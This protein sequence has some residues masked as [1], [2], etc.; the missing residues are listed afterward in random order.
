MKKYNSLVKRTNKLANSVASQFS[1]SVNI[2]ENFVVYVKNNN[3]TAGLTLETKIWTVE[4]TAI[5]KTKTKIYDFSWNIEIKSFHSTIIFHRYRKFPKHN[6][7]WVNKWRRIDFL[8]EYRCIST[9]WLICLLLLYRSLWNEI[10]VL[11]LAS[12]TLCKLIFKKL[13]MG[14]W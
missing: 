2:V 12:S 1:K 10:I 9:Y 7:R 11:L 13:R 5:F 8:F 14:R 4:T 3:S 6:Y